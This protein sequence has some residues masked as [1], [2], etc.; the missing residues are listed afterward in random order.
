MNDLEKKEP[1]YSNNTVGKQSSASSQGVMPPDEQNT[2]QVS[3]P[4]NQC[5]T[6][7][8]I[9]SEEQD[10]KILDA[11]DEILGKYSNQIQ[12]S[13]TVEPQTP[14]KKTT[15]NKTSKKGVGFLSLGLVL[16]FLGIMMLYCLFSP[17]H[18]FSIVLKL[19]PICAVLI[20][21]ELFFNQI[22][23]QGRFKV[24]IPSVLISAV[25][26]VGCCVMCTTL[27]NKFND[28]EEEYNNRTIAA[29]IYDLSYQ[30]LRYTADID[31]LDVKVDLNPDGKGIIDGFKSLSTDDNVDISI[32]IAGIISSPKDFSRICKEIINAYRIMGIDVT[33]FYFS[34]E[35][36][37][38]TYSLSV[39][40][41][42]AQD[43]SPEEL[44]VYVNHI[45]I[46]D[47]D[48]LEDLE[49]L[50]ESNEES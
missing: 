28:R 16:I 49:D 29:Q 42:F 39:E 24:N 32:R 45:Y 40:G 10:K 33:N 8:S 44:E 26:T 18:D 30:E 19:S 36:S 4:A 22:A 35:S 21:M 20:G 9:S 37:L 17:K 5:I 2:E 48:Y 47:M 15:I 11:L 38:H 50:V 34:N 3:N 1:V 43:Y 25:L 31:K 13:A 27:T 7:N 46:K 23:N 12:N 41:K 6:D 14:K